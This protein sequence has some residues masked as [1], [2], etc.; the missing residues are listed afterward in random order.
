MNAI[1]RARAI[2]IWV[3]LCLAGAWL[4][5]AGA[6]AA[7]GATPPPV[8]NWVQTGT[9][10]FPIQVALFRSQGV[11][12]DG[13][14]LW[15]SWLN[16]ISRTDLAG[17]EIFASSYHD[18]IP[19]F[20]QGT[21]HN[22]IGDID[23]H[24]GILY[25]PIEDGPRYLS[26]WIV[27]YRADT[28]EWTGRS[29]ELPH[30]YLTE[31]VPW[32]AID[33]PRGVAYTAEWND[34][35]RLNVHRLTDFQLLDTVELDKKVPRIQGAKVFRGSLYIARDN[36]SE[37]SIEAIDPETGHVTH[38]FDRNLGD[39]YEAEGIA[40][41]RQPTGTVMLTT[42]IYQGNPMSVQM[43][44]YRINGDSVPPA[45]THLRLTPSRVRPGRRAAPL[46][47]RL[48]SSEPATA[49]IRW[50]RCSG[51]KG[52]C[53][54]STPRG[55][56]RTVQLRAGANRLQLTTKLRRGNGSSSPMRPG[57]WLLSVIPVD[58]ADV[59]GKPAKARLIVVKPKRRHR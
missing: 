22:H 1:S 18:A 40:F 6:S 8:S 46:T 55:V 10:T 47:V 52:R 20:L 15:F 2:S 33:G 23:V 5:M 38:L 13:H 37:Q 49:R 26:P 9:T 16:G 43:R 19:T 51:R 42:D 25:A 35:S 24:D 27:L 59:T 53:D 29:Y 31:G 28:L 56:E 14:S 11:A 21:S 34:T 58:Q 41:V 57:K 36:G 7:Q 3:A 39:D 30:A 44:S 4:S 17:D 32:V 12:S 48:R 50:R 45:L 54:R